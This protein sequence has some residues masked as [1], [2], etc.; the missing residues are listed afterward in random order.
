MLFS[1]GEDTSQI[2]PVTM[3]RLASTAGVRIQTVGVGTTAGTT[4]QIGRVQRRDGAGSADAEDVATVTNGSY[5]QVEQLRGLRP[6]R[7]SINLHFTVVTE[8]TEITALF[9]AAA[10]LVLVL[11]RS[12]P[13]AVVR[14]G[15]VR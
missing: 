2:D 10:A 14:A 1:D 8:H 3:A 6:F 15:G 13:C 11:G 5:Q 7:K 9:A 12:C 4:V